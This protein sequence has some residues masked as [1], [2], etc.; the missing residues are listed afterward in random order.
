MVHPP[1]Q[2]ASHGAGGVVP[3]KES[4][5]GATAA[6]P[7]Y[8]HAVI[9]VGV[10][11]REVRLFEGLSAATRKH[12]EDDASPSLHCQRSGEPVHMIVIAG[13]VKKYSCTAQ[14]IVSLQTA[15]CCKL[16]YLT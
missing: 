15:G 14:P 16:P 6:V 12:D 10:G 9:D 1:T 8:L 5:V 11:S 2:V 3:R 7:L 4:I 13:I